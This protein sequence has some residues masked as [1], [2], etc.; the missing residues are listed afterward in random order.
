MNCGNISSIFTP[1]YPGSRKPRLRAVTHFGVQAW[2]LVVD[3]C[4]VFWPGYRPTGTLIW[5]H[6]LCPWGSTV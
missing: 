6:G 1:L 4:A 5:N 2:P 3:E